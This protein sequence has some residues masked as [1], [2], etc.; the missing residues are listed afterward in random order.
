M[1]VRIRKPLLDQNVIVT[2]G[3]SGIGRSTCISLAGKGASVVVVDIN[4][5]GAEETAHQ[6][7]AQGCPVEPIVLNKDVGSE[8]QMEE[9]GRIVEGHFGRIDNLIHCAG[10]LRGKNSG[11][12]LMADVSL[13]EWDEVI[14]VN[15]K[16]TFLCNRAVLPA[17]I[18]QRRGQ[19]V[20][21]SSTSGLRGR[22][23]DSV[24]CAS[25]FGVVGMSQSLMEEVRQYGIKVH[26]VLPDAVNTPMWDQNG[27]V[28]ASEDALSPVRVADLIAYVL[29]LPEDT[30]LGELVIAPFKTR[31]RKKRES[32]KGT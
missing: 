16:G 8:E 13:A 32:G 30:M 17:M 27:P 3:G 28:R 18:K 25:K 29:T 9:M 23:F 31:H 7:K 11:P 20:N 12:K 1:T 6:L 5:R 2:G 21:I 10:I 15:L 24:Y 14:E 22:A 19:I 4:S 26:V